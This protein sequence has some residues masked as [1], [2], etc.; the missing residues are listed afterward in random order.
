M[1]LVGKP[2]DHRNAGMACQLFHLSVHERADDDAVQIAGEQAPDIGHAF[3]DAQAQVL[4]LQEERQPTQ[5]KH[6][7]LEGHARAAG[8][9]F[10]DHPQRA[11]RQKAVGHAAF[12]MIL[13]ACGQ[14][15]HGFQLGPG[16][17]VQ[18]EKIALHR[19]PPYT[20]PNSSSSV[21]TRRST[22]RSLTMSGGKK[23]STVST[24]QLTRKPR[25]RQAVTNW[26]PGKS[27]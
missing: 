22:S 2:V 13:K 17:I 21:A 23:R 12:E 18:G 20:F 3:P 25:S 19:W 11:P 6:A 16:Q 14:L 24:V 10:K 26:P 27:S 7:D 8:G 4:I 15:Q 1:V 5:L 9:F